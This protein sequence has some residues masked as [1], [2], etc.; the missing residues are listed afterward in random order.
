MLVDNGKMT[1]AFTRINEIKDSFKTEGDQF[2]TDL[3]QI[4]NT[5]E[6]ETKDILMSQKIGSVD[7]QDTKTLA[8]FVGTQIPNL[9]D[10]LAKLLEANRTTVVDTDKKLSEAITPGNN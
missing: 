6:G 5:F 8:Y 7:S 1:Q 10:G 3:T 4:L 9:I 2:I